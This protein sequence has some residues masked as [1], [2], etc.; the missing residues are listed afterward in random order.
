M[1]AGI[2]P[3]PGRWA[4]TCRASCPWWPTRSASSP[5]GSSPWFRSRSMRAWPAPGWSQT[6]AWSERSGTKPRA[7]SAL[8]HGRD[9]EA[10]VG[11]LQRAFRPA[12]GHGLGLG[13]EAQTFHAVLVDVAEGRALPAAEGVIGHRHRDRHID[14]DHADVDAG[15]EVAR[16]AAV[17]GEDGHA[18]AVLV[19]GRQ[20]ERL[21][22]GLGAQDLQ[23]RPEDLLVVGLH[24]RLDLVEQGRP[25]EEALLVAL[26]A[27]LAPVD[28]QLGA[29]LHRRVDP[30]Q[31][32]L[33]VLGGDDGAVE[34]LHVGGDA[35]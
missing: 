10:G 2:R 17:L 5:P 22:K 27:E 34:G 9:D 13:P 15:G 1:K 33:L 29:F 26:Q 35:D 28:N 12:G 31:D 21:L 14:P 18:V 25:D 11:V 30:A 19:L 4:R 6:G 20:G 24:V 8:G 7:K 3:W 32:A 23:H 16:R